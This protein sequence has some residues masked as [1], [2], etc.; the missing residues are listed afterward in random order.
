MVIFIFYLYQRFYI[1]LTYCGEQL[2]SSSFCPLALPPSFPLPSGII[3]G[4]CSFILAHPRMLPHIAWCL[5]SNSNNTSIIPRGVPTKYS[6]WYQDTTLYGTYRYLHRPSYDTCIVPHM[7]LAQ[8]LTWY[9]HSSPI[10]TLHGT[11]IL[12]YMVSTQRSQQN[13]KQLH[14]VPYIPQQIPAEHFIWQLH[15]ISHGAYIGNT[16]GTS[17]YYTYIEPH[18]VS[19]CRLTLLFPLHKV[20]QGEVPIFLSQVGF[21][22]LPRGNFSV[23]VHFPSP[24]APSCSPCPL[25]RLLYHS[26]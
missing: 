13:S 19:V 15:N 6:A 5:H 24:A 11:Q 12:F 2:Y 20:R 16:Y 14:S 3:L 18:M 23:V 26:A 25:Q 21:S 1:E 10:G 17:Q 7:I 22:C 9:Q 8:C 4:K